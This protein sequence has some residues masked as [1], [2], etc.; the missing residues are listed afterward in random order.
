MQAAGRGVS[1]EIDVNA[2]TSSLK[3]FNAELSKTSKSIRTTTKDT[4]RAGS[5]FSR[6]GANVVT[7]NQGL[8]LMGKATALVKF[9]ALIS[10]ASYAAQAVNNLAA[11]ATSLVGALSPLAGLLGAAPALYGALGQAAGVVALS[12]VSELGEAVGGLNE[13]MDKTGESFKALSPQAQKLAKSLNQLKG[14]IREI[15]ADVQQP[16]FEGMNRGIDEATKNLPAFR[17]VMV[18]TS[19]ELGKL[20]EEAGRFAGREGFG[21]DMEAVGK[22]NAQ[23]LGRLGDAGLHFADALRHVM[24]EA[25]PLVDFLGKSVLK[26]A[27]FVEEEVKAGRESGKLRDFFKETKDLLK[28]LVPTFADLGEGIWNVVRAGKPLGDDILGVLADSAEE[29]RKWTESASGKNAIVQWYQDARKPLEQTAKLVRDVGELF[30][31]IGSGGGLGNMIKTLR[32]DMLP[33]VREVL[34]SGRGFGP[35]FV[36]FVVQATQ[37]LKP[38][39]GASG[40][41]TL[42]VKGATRLL[43]LFNKLI[44]AVP[45]LG[46]V[47]ATYFGARAI[48][49]LFGSGGL[50]GMLGF[51]SLGALR[52]QASKVGSTL[53][54]GLKGGFGSVFGPAGIASLVIDSFEQ[55]SGPRKAV[56]DFGNAIENT[57][58]QA[59]GVSRNAAQGIIHQG[60]RLDKSFDQLKAGFNSTRRDIANDIENL[61]HT[62]GQSLGEI[63]RDSQDNMA[64]IRQTMGTESRAGRQAVSDNFFAVVQAIKNSMETGEI[65]A[66]KGAKAIH[67]VL[68]KQLKSYGIS[69]PEGFITRSE[70]VQETGGEGHR[71]LQK[72]GMV[73]GRGTG[74]KVPLHIGGRLAAVVEPGEYVS[75]A[76]RK[77]TAALMGANRRVPR[78]QDGG[79]V[80]GE[81]Q[82]RAD[83][84]GSGPGF[85]PYMNYLNSQF[86]P[87]NVISGIRPGSIVAGSGTLSN[88]SWGGAVDISTPGGEGATVSNPMTGAMGA[89]MDSAH[90]F[91]SQKFAPINL[92][93]LWRTL[94][95]GNHYNHIH[96]GIAR[97]HSFN[98]DAMREFIS[99]LPEGGAIGGRVKLPRYISGGTGLGGLVAT[100]LN[101]MAAGTETTMNRRLD[102]R[103][104]TPSFG[105]SDMGNVHG[106]TFSATSYGPPWG[107]IQGTGVT[108]TGVDLT[109]SPH[110]YGVAVDPNVI[111][112]GKRLRI[113][114]NPFNYG[115]AFKAFDTGG[116]IQGNRIDFYDW[117]GRDEQLG[118]GTRNV[119]VE[120]L[121][122]G[123]I[124]KGFQRGGIVQGLQGGGVVQGHGGES[125]STPLFDWFRVM[126]DQP[127]VDQMKGIV[128]KI[129]LHPARFDDM[130]DWYGEALDYD[131]LGTVAMELDTDDPITGETIY[132]IARG[133]TAIGG[134]GSDLGQGWLD[135]ELGQLILVRDRILT[136]IPIVE[137]LTKFVKDKIDALT[138]PGKNS[139]ESIAKRLYDDAKKAYDDLQDK[140]ENLRTQIKR[141]E[142]IKKPTDAQKQRLSDLK[143]RLNGLVNALGVAKQV[144]DDSKFRVG[145]V[146]DVAGAFSAR[147]SA[148]DA[149]KVALKTDGAEDGSWPSLEELQ[150]RTGEAGSIFDTKLEIDS[151][152][153]AAGEA[154]SAAVTEPTALQALNAELL[155]QQLE[156]QRRLTAIAEAQTPIFEQFGGRIFHSGGIIGGIG[157][158]SVVARSGEG[159]FTEEQMAA[160]GGSNVTVVVEDG[161]VDP[162]KIRVVVNDELSSVAARATRVGGTKGQKAVYR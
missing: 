52:G 7:A 43:E 62:W 21:R 107:G 114:P 129:D 118:W 126:F 93:L 152:L 138:K 32:R 10:G 37:A 73:P 74:D 15:Q 54:L 1:R 97:S 27:E 14:P 109:N 68:L 145:A 12:G 47:L 146:S 13:K 79:E 99:H 25:Q 92:D 141:L 154:A 89:R 101:N 22:N 158:Q 55:M 103:A 150:G 40:P 66:K 128:G 33:A 161:A 90:R 111:P 83:V 102:A 8:G 116:A 153:Q 75:V 115:G 3:G 119:E 11:G 131:E 58:I 127:L 78:F 76:N 30:F 142:G 45:V 36:D 9:P 157:E 133:R 86:G 64:R 108:A 16:L 34:K 20:A 18:A 144:M 46:N 95:G 29:F 56:K 132:G 63:R 53:G 39:L 122:R 162:N 120:A 125:P 24:V 100:G 123:G 98:P 19:E 35:V 91:I 151:G 143:G 160:M 67:K 87:L 137:T 140:I 17:D 72:G 147:A 6:F 134:L 82:T 42:F 59:L 149:V 49:R 69:D 112:L 77:A 70:S 4:D 48:G 61:S 113:S 156:E 44:D 136:A 81:F 106:D 50:L 51:G 124:V 94:T 2:D 80:T 96:S 38:F 31:D 110:I 41:L 148:L 71:G 65:S 130:S 121:R 28:V 117:R 26:F 135:L 139:Y 155:Q 104:M 5:A 23:L 57:F 105:M 88:H 85:I 60:N 159:I 84:L